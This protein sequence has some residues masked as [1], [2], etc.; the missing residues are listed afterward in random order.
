[1]LLRQGLP[2]PI[3]VWQ[4]VLGLVLVLATAFLCVAL[5]ARVFQVGILMQGKGAN[6]KEIV[7]W[8]FYGMGHRPARPE[9]RQDLAGSTQ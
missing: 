3:P 4:P 9:R 6:V 7:Q 8:A 1:M 2:A 5:A